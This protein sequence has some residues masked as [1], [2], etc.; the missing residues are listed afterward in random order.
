MHKQIYGEQFTNKLKK[1][2]PV[3]LLLFLITIVIGITYAI[4]T[5]TKEGSINTITTGNITMS[6]TEN[7]NVISL[8]NAL[9]K[10]DTL[11]KAQDEYFD[12]S[13]TTNTN[14]DEDYPN[15]E[16]GYEITL[17]PLSVDTNYTKLNDN[18]IKVYLE[19]KDNSSILTSPTLISA[20]TTSNTNKVLYKGKHIHS[21]ETSSI[22]TNYRLRAWID[23]NTDASDFNTTSYQYKFRININGV[24]DYEVP[25]VELY[26]LVASQSLGTD[27][28]NNINYAKTPTTGA[29]TLGST[30][31]DEYPVYFYRGAVTNNNIVFGKYCW[32]IVRTTST[33]G[34]KLIYNGEYTESNKCNNTGTASRLSSTSAFN[35]SNDKIYYVGYYYDTSNTWQNLNNGTALNTTPSDIAT[36]IN[37]WYASEESGMTNLTKWLENEKWC[38]DRTNDGSKY[39]GA[40]TRLASSSSNVNPSIECPNNN[41]AF[42]LSVEAGGVKDYGNNVLPYPVG[43]LTADEATLAGSGW[44]GYSSSAYLKSGFYYWLASPSSFTSGYAYGIYVDSYGYLDSNYVVGS[45][46]VRPSVSLIPGAEIEQ[47]N[48][49][50]ASDPYV[51]VLK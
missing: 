14:L 11:G 16:V 17:E 49:G 28:E 22:T 36:A 1:V 4:A 8:T 30:A 10:S 29:Y 38:N 50:T 33:G 3:T 41:D 45:R 21:Y 15:I 42:T 7:T 26:S 5:Y 23:Y 31:S 34:V 43:L 37:T 32:K 47:G 2:L 25:S 18:Q 48:T 19:N 40:R 13:V 6:Y 20:L 27:T 46:G 12:F 9:P 24:A 44:Y 35:S 39:F 51:V